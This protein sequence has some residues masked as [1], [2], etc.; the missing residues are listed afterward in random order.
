M[1]HGSTPITHHISELA[2]YPAINAEILAQYAAVRNSDEV[3]RS[4]YF[5][6]RYE[7]IYVNENLVPALQPV[8]SA[9]RQIAGTLL[10]KSGPALSVG[11]WF[12][13]MAPG[14]VTLPHRHD[15]D[16]ELASAVYYVSVPP[17]SGELLLN[18]AETQTALVPRAGQFI[19]FAPD[20]L[21]EVTENRSDQ[22]RL[23]IGMNFGIRA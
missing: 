4:H 2:G 23:S 5:G 8:L 9:A 6:G 18:H 22:T 10:S 13:E 1:Q 16:D 7:N 21:H 12:N 15:E 19:F 11:Y 14:Q 17:N 3:R 20:L